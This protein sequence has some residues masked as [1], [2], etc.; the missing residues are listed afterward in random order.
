MTMC[1]K[2]LPKVHY[3]QAYPNIHRCHTWSCY[4]SCY[5]SPR[6]VL[7]MSVQKSVH[8]SAALAVIIAPKACPF[9]VSVF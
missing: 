5:M 9:D 8:A 2:R 1:I 3:C 6:S 4:R 7:Q